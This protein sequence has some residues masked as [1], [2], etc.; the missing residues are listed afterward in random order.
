MDGNLSRHVLVRTVRLTVETNLVT[1]K[2]LKALDVIMWPVSHA[3]SATASIVA[4]VMVAVFPV[5]GSASHVRPSIELDASNAVLELVYVPVCIRFHF[6][7][8]L[9][10]VSSDTFLSHL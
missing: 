4:L 5:S 1:S 3:R 6:F 2:R 9:S 8:S 7:K 10:C